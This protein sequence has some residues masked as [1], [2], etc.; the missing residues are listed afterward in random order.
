LNGDE[1]RW[2]IPGKRLR[3]LDPLIVFVVLREEA[4]ALATF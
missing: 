2:D 3:H 1:C 4:A